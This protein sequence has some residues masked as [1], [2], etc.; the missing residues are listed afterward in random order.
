MVDRQYRDELLDASY[1]A[2][3]LELENT[4]KDLVELQER[5]EK[6]RAAAAALGEILPTN[7]QVSDAKMPPF[8]RESNQ[9]NGLEESQSEAPSSSKEAARASA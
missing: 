8:L 2:V 4:E 9:S 6:L 3:K 7:G 1:E 5:A